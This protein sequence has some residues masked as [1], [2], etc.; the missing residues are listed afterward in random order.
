M[1]YEVV[2]NFT[3]DEF[4]AYFSPIGRGFLLS[5]N[6]F[7]IL[8]GLTGNGIVAYGSIKHNAIQM[9]RVSVMFIENLAITDMLLTL[10]LFV[11]AF[12]TLAAKRWIYGDLFCVVSAF[13]FRYLP[14]QNEISIICAMSVYRLWI[15]K[16]PQAYRDSFSTRKVRLLMVLL[17]LVSLVPG[18]CMFFMDHSHRAVF[19][20]KFVSCAP[21]ILSE[22]TQNGFI[23][24]MAGLFVGIPLIICIGTNSLIIYNVIYSAKQIGTRTYHK[25]VV[26]LLLYICI[27]FILSHFAFF[28]KI[29]VIAMGYTV[30]DWFENLALYMIS[31]NVVGNPVIYTAKNEHF[32]QYVKTL[33]GICQSDNYLIRKERC[34]DRSDKD[35]DNE[36]PLK[37]SKHKDNKT[38]PGVYKELHNE[39][40]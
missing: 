19:H 37:T 16:M 32:R 13:I 34:S 7:I 39:S 36:T 9:D 26:M 22:T 10:V 40:E 31:V 27:A 24:V 6:A 25:S 1:L 11:P 17:F 5:I 30:P 8:A 33:F 20:A 14:M 4:E 18:T 15:L 3:S 38:I 28:L 2:T 35:S 21:G 23:L 29:G 12:I